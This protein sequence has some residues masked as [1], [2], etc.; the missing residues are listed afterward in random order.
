[1]RAGLKVA[2]ALAAKGNQGAQQVA[3]DGGP[4]GV[5]E[6]VFGGLQGEAVHILPRWA[7]VVVIRGLGVYLRVAG[8]KTLESGMGGFRMHNPGHD[9]PPLA[10]WKS[11]WGF[12][13]PP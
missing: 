4:E 10:P 8:S 11:L 5:K 3:A 2:V 6:Y 12:G 7:S 1:M 13:T 9:P